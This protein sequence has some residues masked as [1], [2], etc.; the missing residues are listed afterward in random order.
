MWDTAREAVRV[1][2]PVIPKI[3]QQTSLARAVSYRQKINWIKNFARELVRRFPLI[4]TQ[5]VVGAETADVVYMWGAFPKRID[6]PFV[7][8]LDN[9][10]VL[11]Y[12]NQSFLHLRMRT[13]KQK[14]R[15]AKQITFLSET[16]KHHFLELFG[17]DFT[18]QAKVLPPFMADNYKTN[19]RVADGTVRF[20]FVGLGFRRKGGP[21]LLK[22]FSQLPHKNA[23][24][25]IIAP[26][27]DDMKKKYAHDTRITFLPP[28]PREVLFSEIYPTHDVF[29]FPSILETLGVVILE[30]LSFGMGIITTDVYATPEMVKNG[31]N[32]VLLNHP[33]LPKVSLNGVMVVDPVTIPRKQFTDR[34][35]GEEQFYES[36]ATETAS[37]LELA[38]SSSMEWKKQ[39]E[40]L[41]KDRFS[42]ARWEERL[43]QIL[44]T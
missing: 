22:A 8:E 13:L 21:E 44:G 5:P 40:A 2:E 19:K 16:A 20:L 41:F 18:D 35:Q 9:P 42:P 33:F 37:A 32:G 6:K 24:L 17:S 3:Q 28:Q 27:S 12:Y 29:V 26:V 39:S 43:A 1:C 14:L 25:T 11:S 31:M 34:Y 4:N 7:I 30:A 15:Q 36:L 23:R 38:M 10:Y